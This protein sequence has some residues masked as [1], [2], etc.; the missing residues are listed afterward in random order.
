MSAQPSGRAGLAWLLAAGC[1]GALLAVV[2]LGWLP[3]RARA[4][5]SDSPAP[6]STD[7]SALASAIEKL[8]QRLARIEA[9]LAVQDSRGAR[10]LVSSTAPLPS[11]PAGPDELHNDLLQLSK[12]VDTLTE[13]LR[14]ARK[15]IAQHPTLEQMRSAREEVDWAFVDEVRRLC[16]D[17]PSAGLERVRLMSF[18]DLL[19]KVGP[20]TGIAANDGAWWYSR[21]V[22][23]SN[24]GPT[25]RGITLRFIRDYVIS[26]EGDGED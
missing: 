10:E 5:G 21:L 13:S 25:H 12:R 4:A 15:P 2:F 24:G 22:T 11:G 14:D 8:D 19:R 20:P 1:A 18:D 23:D 26:V 7:S 17:N 16:L 6:V 9:S 3:E